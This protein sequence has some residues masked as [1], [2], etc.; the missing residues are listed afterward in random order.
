MKLPKV[1]PN[2]ICYSKFPIIFK[3]GNK[4]IKEN[5]KEVNGWKSDI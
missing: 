4:H 5:K 2:L 1:L 3:Y